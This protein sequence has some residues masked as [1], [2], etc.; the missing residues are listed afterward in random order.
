MAFEFPILKM[1]LDFV[2]I[3]RFKVFTIEID[4]EFRIFTSGNRFSNLNFHF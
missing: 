1:D 3:G 4:F 2:L